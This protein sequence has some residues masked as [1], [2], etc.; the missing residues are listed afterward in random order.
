MLPLQYV[1]KKQK[2]QHTCN[3]RASDEA[4]LLT[5]MQKKITKYLSDHFYQ[6]Y[7]LIVFF[8]FHILTVK[9]KLI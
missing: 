8:E 3:D 5:Y 2:S 7:Y 6:A 1:L 9:N 4:N